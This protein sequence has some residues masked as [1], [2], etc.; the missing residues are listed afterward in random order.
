LQ[1]ESAFADFDQAI[2]LD[3]DYLP[4]Y[5]QRG[6]LFWETADFE[7]A[8]QDLDQIG[9]LKRREAVLSAE[10]LGPDDASDRRRPVLA[11]TGNAD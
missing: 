11:V 7:R 1:Y 9:R 3:A 4:A 8:R 10:E 5:Y 6:S 2:G